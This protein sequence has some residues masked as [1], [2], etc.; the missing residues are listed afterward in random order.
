MGMQRTWPEKEPE[1]SS[2]SPIPLLLGDPQNEPIRRT[3]RS[4]RSLCSIWW[5]RSY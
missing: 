5:V 2:P 3:C 1:E 4:G